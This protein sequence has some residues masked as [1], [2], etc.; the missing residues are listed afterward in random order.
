MKPA[1]PA[2][3]ARLPDFIVIGAMKGGSTTLWGLLARHP[4]IFMCEP[5]E[6]QFFSRTERFERGLDSY[7]SLFA[8]ASPAQRV[9]EASTC[10]SRWPHYGDVAKRIAD[11]VPNVKLVYQLRHPV[12]R[13]YSHYKHLM[14]ER[15]AR[16]TGPLVSF[17]QALEEVP[18]ILDASRYALQIERYLAHFPR[19][20]LLVLTLDDLRARP[21]ETWQEL[22][23]FLD[24]TPQ[25]I[26]SGGLPI[27]NASGTKVARGGMRQ[28]VRRVRSLPGWARI[29]ALMPANARRGVRAWLLRPEVARRIQGARMRAH[30]ES[31]SPLDAASRH[32]ILERLD[33][34]T[35]A[36]ERFLGRELPEWRA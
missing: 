27:D 19:A 4:Q 1:S 21:L 11:C 16:G 5:K 23:A 14:E 7:R 10:Y 2:T 15:V 35:R 6:P 24:V 30:Q 25:E 31:V 17:A 13:A 3:G 32:S 26:A 9:G 33:E 36:L 12:E 22:Q 28:I 20:Q 29:K 8:S 34:Q 18:E